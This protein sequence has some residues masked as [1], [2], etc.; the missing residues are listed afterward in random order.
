MSNGSNKKLGAGRL[1]SGLLVT[2]AL[3]LSLYVVHRVNTAPRTDDAYA[4]ADTVNVAPEVNG[5]IIDLRV[6]DN[7]AVHQGDVLF[8][9]D[10]R[11]FQ[12]AL[13]AAKASL[14]TLEQEIMLTQRSVDAQTFGAESAA[15]SVDRAAAM[16]KQATDTRERMEPLLGNGFVSAEQLDQAKTAERS[17]KVQLETAKIE[18]Q[19]AKAGISGVEA[20]VARREVLKAQI[21]QAQ[22]NL[23]YATVKAP[24]D[25]YVAGLKIAT[26]QYAAAGHPLFTLVDTDHWYV[27]AN[28]RETELN[29]IRPGCAA[30]VYLLSEPGLRY[31]GTVESVGFG[32]FPEEGGND[33]SGLPKVPRTINWVRVHQRFPVRILVPHADLSKFRL[34]ESA[35]ATVMGPGA[36]AR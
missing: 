31:R 5:R 6:T 29:Q 22:L 32:V 26:G 14:E 23:E 35:V 30:Q 2:A 28:F 19:R 8:C 15:S 16:A 9:L 10:P 27:V 34:G 4:Y 1:A 33:A 36:P 12:Y 3:G 13:D 11:P 7:Q 18:A 25:G 24:C 17:A 20:L 21:A